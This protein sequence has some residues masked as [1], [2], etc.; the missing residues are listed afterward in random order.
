[1]EAKAKMEMAHE[2]RKKLLSSIRGT[3][4]TIPNLRPIF[5]KY[6]GAVNPNYVALIPVVNSRLERLVFSSIRVLF[7]AWSGRVWPARI[8]SM[9][10]E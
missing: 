10:E 6:T 1:M 7:L 3:T 4:V 2:Q 8:P 9:D 5:E